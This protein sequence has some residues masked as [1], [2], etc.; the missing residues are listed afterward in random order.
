M[1]NIP[2]Y[3]Y[4]L[5]PFKPKRK[6]KKTVGQ[7]WGVERSLDFHWEKEN[8]TARALLVKSSIKLE[9]DRKGREKRI[10][11]L[12]KRLRELRAKLNQRQY[13]K[14]RYVQD[15]LKTILK[16]NRFVK[17]LTI[18]LRGETD[19]LRLLVW[20]NQRRLRED[21]KLDGKYIMV[22]NLKDKTA[23]QLL[24]LYKDQSFIE[25]RIRTLKK[26]LKVRPVFLHREERIKGLVFITML[27]LM[28]YSLLERFARQSGL[29]L[30]AR[31]LSE[32]FQDV[33][34]IELRL[35]EKKT[36]IRTLEDFNPAQT[37]ILKK[38]GLKHP[39]FWLFK[40]QRILP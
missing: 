4:G 37:R 26:H 40:E 15:R 16:K 38:L 18:S 8:I 11:A 23:P 2:E 20:R 19:K 29:A 27:A 33:R 36:F 10:Q 35:S 31:S 32:H 6:S 13:R 22:T 12:E 17:Y 34:V 1:A 21:Q 24:R 30:T 7:F 9:V 39:R 5:I 3:L 28:I 25:W 14:K